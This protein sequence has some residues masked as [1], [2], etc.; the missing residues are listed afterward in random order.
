MAHDR[1][2][3]WESGWVVEQWRC[4]CG[5]APVFCGHDHEPR[6]C[7]TC[8]R[9]KPTPRIIGT[10]RAVDIRNKTITVS[11]TVEDPHPLSGVQRNARVGQL[12]PAV[13]WAELPPGEALRQ[14][15]ERLT[16]ELDHGER[17]G[18]IFG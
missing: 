9:P 10:V 14:G 15:F 12:G 18:S 7:P 16:A 11:S 3:I 1:A 4:A 8:K 13:R 6:R 2:G 17:A 5:A